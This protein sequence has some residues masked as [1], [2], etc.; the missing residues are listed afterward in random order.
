M[1]RSRAEERKLDNISSSHI[2]LF[3][4]VGRS[5]PCPPLPGPD[6]PTTGYSGRLAPSSV[7]FT[8]NSLDK[9]RAGRQD[10]AGRVAMSTDG[11][12]P[13]VLAPPDAR[14]LFLGAGKLC[15]G[16]REL[17]WRLAEVTQGEL[18]SGSHILS[19]SKFF[20]APKISARKFCANKMVQHIKFKKIKNDPIKV[21]FL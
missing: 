5:H 1:L 20:C 3:P 9:R 4:P 2:G 15:L 12:Y 21:K 13:S 19:K 11:A 8:V 17:T 6:R 7:L 14:E 10:R 18:Q 16:A